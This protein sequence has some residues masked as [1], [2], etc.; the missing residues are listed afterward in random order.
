MTLSIKTI[1][2]ILKE[3]I[4]KGHQNNDYSIL[5]HTRS[6]DL[7]LLDIQPIE[8]C[9]TTYSGSYLSFDLIPMRFQ[10]LSFSAFVYLSRTFVCPDIGLLLLF[11]P[12]PSLESIHFSFKRFDQMLTFVFS[13]SSFTA[14]L[15]LVIFLILVGNYGTFQ[16]SP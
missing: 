13:V 16:F 4:K 12:F 8:I 14:F 11:L 7:I 6:I 3:H 10:W 1:E 5:N 9:F 2:I 15:K